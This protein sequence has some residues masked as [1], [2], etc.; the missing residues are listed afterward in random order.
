MRL[1]KNVP[2][3]VLPWLLPTAFA[4]MFK[5]PSLGHYRNSSAKDSAVEKSKLE[6]EVKVFED[7]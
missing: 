2:V 1:T 3:A 7:F 5:V 4:V 6:V